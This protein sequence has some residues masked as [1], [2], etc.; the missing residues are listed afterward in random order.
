MKILKRTKG[1]GSETKGSTAFGQN[2]ER[3]RRGEVQAYYILRGQIEEDM[4]EDFMANLAYISKDFC[5]L[6]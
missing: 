4:Q 6:F 3:D 1:R 2:N 5:F